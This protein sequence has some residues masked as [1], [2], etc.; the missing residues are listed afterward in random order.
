M[1]SILIIIFGFLNSAEDYNFKYEPFFDSGKAPFLSR[2]FNLD[3]PDYKVSESKEYGKVYFSFS[4]YS[5][6]KLSSSNYSY[7]D[8]FGDHPRYIISLG[9]E[10]LIFNY[11]G[12]IGIK[13]QIGGFKASGYGYFKDE[14]LRSEESVT[15]YG[16][17]IELL[18]VY[19]FKYFGSNQIL[20]PYIEAGAG[21]FTFIE[22]QNLESSVY[23]KRYIYSYQLG[24]K[25]LLDWIDYKSS[26]KLDSNHGI[27]NSYIFIAYKIINNFDTS[28]YMDF[29]SSYY[30]LGFV[31]DF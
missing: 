31:L 18:F 13:L 7:N 29:S 17:P 16:F 11:F 24:F 3:Y 8:F 15:F 26:W 14:D 27:N 20:V 5:P 9:F 1:L 25:F 6:T 22:K 21:A 19:T 30:Q 23:G 2:V 4:P 28:N 12:D 10:R